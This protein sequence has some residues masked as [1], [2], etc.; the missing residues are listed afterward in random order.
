MPYAAVNGI[1]LHYRVDGVERADAPWLVLSH[2]LGADLSMWFAQVEAFS[3]HFR[4]LRYDT[5]GHGHSEA[6]K[7]PYTL[8]QLLGD[9]LGLFDTLK[10]ARANFCGI[11]MGG[12]TGI[13]LAARHPQRLNR[14]VL[15]NTAA[16]IGLPEIWLP[17]AKR[18]REEG[19]RG[20]AN[21]VLP[22]WFSAKFI[23][24]EP[25]I[26]AQ[27]HDVFVRTNPEGYA[28][29]CE[30]INAADLRGELAGIRVPSLVITGTHDTSTPVEQG[31]AL[32]SGMCGARYIE[33]DAFHISN[34]E[35]ASEFTP[36]VLDF[37]TG[38]H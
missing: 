18:A 9:A 36:A 28:S 6:P 21:E 16:R 14:V 1:N 13:A 5:R 20:I 35:R 26:F 22:R 4:V 37:L 11:S 7:G 33:L 10:I 19:L 3:R 32:A 25:R 17:R 8:E 24:S 15:S 27:V 38:S 30:A 34:I 29:N 12:L 23:E 2:S 31:C